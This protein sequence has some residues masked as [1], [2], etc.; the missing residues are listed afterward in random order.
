MVKAA[1]KREPSDVEKLQRSL[2]RDS[3]NRE[4]LFTRVNLEMSGTKT[5]SSK[6][7]T[8]MIITVFLSLASGKDNRWITR[9]TTMRERFLLWR[10]LAENHAV[11]VSGLLSQLQSLDALPKAMK[12]PP[13]KRWK[14]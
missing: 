10:L 6:L 3:F 2:L 5:T 8:D 1:R 14:K 7:N 13:G 9:S 4:Q 11:D 12:A